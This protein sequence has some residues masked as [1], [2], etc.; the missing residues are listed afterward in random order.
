MYQ[1]LDYYKKQHVLVQ[2][3]L[4]K[5]KTSMDEWQINEAETIIGCYEEFIAN[6]EILDA[7]ESAWLNVY[8][9]RAEDGFVNGAQADYY[10]TKQDADNN[11][12][13]ENR[14]SCLKVNLP[15]GVFDND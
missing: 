9:T 13:K 2:E 15:I 10:D 4:N 3:A 1:L 8:Y 5:N 7:P 12:R 6:I 11:I 14:L